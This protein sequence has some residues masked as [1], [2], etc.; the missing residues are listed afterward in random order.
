[1]H[2]Y[3]FGKGVGKQVWATYIN[4][5]E[6]VVHPEEGGSGGVQERETFFTKNLPADNLKVRLQTV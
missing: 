1:L 3:F 2:I 5:K 4:R 6:C